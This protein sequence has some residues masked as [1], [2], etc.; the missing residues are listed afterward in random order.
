MR[1][2]RLIGPALAAI[3][4]S[5]LAAAFFEVARMP[6]LF[7]WSTV[8]L[9]ALLTGLLALGL[10]LML[11]PGLFFTRAERMRVDLYTATGLSGANSE[12]LISTVQQAEGFA[13]RLR[14]A[15]PEM[16]EDAAGVAI[17][18][19][20]DLEELAARVTAEPATVGSASALITRA[21]LVVEAVEN[22]VEYKQDTG[23]RETEVDQARARI[24]D[25]LAQMSEA[26]DA[27]HVRQAQRRLTDLEVA[28]DVADDLFGR[29]QQ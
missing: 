3:V 20:E 19:A 1:S 8:I 12:R 18:A 17:A 7:P 6:I 27:V 26:T 10:S 5:A 2:A 21:R 23:A 29:P 14:E 11:P 16:R 9:P 25:S 24:M 22:F 15:S 28:T 4:A 13:R